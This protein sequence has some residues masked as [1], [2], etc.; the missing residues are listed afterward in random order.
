[1]KGV[2]LKVN[3]RIVRLSINLQNIVNELENDRA[4]FPGLTHARITVFQK[5][6]SPSISQSL[7]HS[8]SQPALLLSYSDGS[9][10]A[11]AWIV[12][13]QSPCLRRA[14]DNSRLIQYFPALL[15]H[16]H[17]G[18]RRNRIRSGLLPFVPFPLVPIQLWVDFDL[19]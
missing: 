11:P 17:E 2:P 14:S 1:M 6:L 8:T 13:F 10:P 9:Y 4:P 5:F 7:V 19:I 18:H 15:L 12:Q 16:D 3:K